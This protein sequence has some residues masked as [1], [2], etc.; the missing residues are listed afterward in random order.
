[1]LAPQLWTLLPTRFLDK[2]AGWAFVSAHVTVPSER[3]SRRIKVITEIFPLCDGHELP[4]VVFASLD[5][6][7]VAAVRREISAPFT[8]THRTLHVRPV[9]DSASSAQRRGLADSRFHRTVQAEVRLASCCCERPPP[10]HRRRLPQHVRPHVLPRDSS[11]TGA[12]HVSPVSHTERAPGD[13]APDPADSVGRPGNACGVHSIDTIR[14][15]R[16]GT[17]GRSI[18][19]RS[20]STCCEPNVRGHLRLAHA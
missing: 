8:I 3:A 9:R 5:S 4:S 2:E 19:H 1:M 12:P 17:D 18:G 16:F 6:A 7:I 10:M 14:Q 20:R 15:C 13:R 11:T